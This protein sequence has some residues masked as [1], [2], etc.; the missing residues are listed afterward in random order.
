MSTAYTQDTDP[1]PRRTTDT[2]EL[3]HILSV[4]SA[5]LDSGQVDDAEDLLQ[6]AI[7]AGTDHPDVKALISR[8]DHARGRSTRM[9]QASESAKSAE[10]DIL[11]NFSTPLPGI[12][13]QSAA[14]Q[15]MTRDAESHHSASRTY[16]ALDSTLLACAGAPD[17]L[18]GFV[19][20]AE[21]HAEIGNVEQAEDL[22]QTLSRW[23]EISEVAPGRLMQSLQISLAPGDTTAVIEYATTLI[24]SGQVDALEPF[25]P[26]AISRSLESDPA[27]AR[28]L[29][30]AYLDLR[31]DRVEAQRL[32]IQ[33]VIAN[34]D[35]RDLADS[36]RALVNPSSRLDLLLFRTVAEAVDDADDWLTWLEHLTV[37]IRSNPP[38]SQPD[39]FEQAME[40]ARRLL[41]DERFGLVSGVL[42]MAQGHWQESA[43][44][45]RLTD[46][47]ALRPIEAFTT[48]YAAALA[49]D[50]TN[51]RDAAQAL[52]E[53]LPLAFQDDVEPFATSTRLFG[54]SASP[55]AILN[56]AIE[57]SDT[58]D[59]LVEIQSLRD[60]YPERLEIRSALA[61][62]HLA[63]GN[64]HEAVREL[65]YVAQE[66]EASSNL[67]AM[68]R[69]MRQISGAV[70]KNVEIKAKLIE[71]YLR[72]GVL[73]EAV[74]E[75]DLI[76][77]RYLDRNRTADAVAAFTRAAEVASTIGE[78]A[79]GNALFDK[80]VGADPDNVPVRHAAVAFYLQ[81]GSIKHAT[82]QL[83]EVVR[84]ALVA[85]DRDEAVAALH[86]II[87]LA[88]HDADA[89]HTLGEVLTSLGE[90]T[91]AERVY[92][93]LSTF[94]QHDP[95]LE[96]K[97][98]AL[99]VLAAT[100]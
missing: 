4:A 63:A 65:R 85:D 3:R 96:A 40:D 48:R 6:E 59:A 25:V 78:V 52:F 73:D 1:T 72:R 46:H 58:A 77:D 79:Q 66:H 54:I 39:N 38:T 29:S 14:V 2:Y 80:A 21:L 43:D 51:A 75:M 68:V 61:E 49:F 92:R 42:A 18:P 94:T 55:G 57:I 74:R 8:L 20:L 86:Q 10:R 56:R 22:F 70:P 31:P 69:A 41:P 62:V 50:Q 87:A 76:G 44:S 82:D 17:F 13:G 26:A 89:Y 97:Q 15:R 9:F 53:T 19:R 12:E 24:E 99:A 95:V 11:V 67:G 98:S 32:H 90:Y 36:A 7:D 81:T 45:F 91:Q 33:A 28:R 27:T 37:A 35:V 34:G 64:V 30:A 83:R 23:Y 5:Y 47:S 93:R 16:T 60:A 71:G 88:P 84:I 100:Q